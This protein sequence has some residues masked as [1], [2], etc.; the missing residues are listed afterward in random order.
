MLYYMC[1]ETKTIKEPTEN[2]NCDE[3]TEAD[4]EQYTADYVSA[5]PVNTTAR[6]KWHCHRMTYN[7]VHL[8]QTACFIC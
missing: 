5:A 6:D 2:T 3:R 7:H 8:M 4:K 1:A